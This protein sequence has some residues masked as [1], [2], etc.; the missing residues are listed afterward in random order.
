[1]FSFFSTPRDA[2]LIDPLHFTYGNFLV[3]ASQ[4]TLENVQRVRD[5]IQDYLS[6]LS[7]SPP[8]KQPIGAQLLVSYQNHQWIYVLLQ[9]VWTA[10]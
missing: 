8:K 6:T 7:V 2:W 5:C 9:N 10:R 1:M 3:N 4:A